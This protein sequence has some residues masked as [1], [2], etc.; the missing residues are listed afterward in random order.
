MASGRRAF[1]PG[2][3]KCFVKVNSPR[4]EG[5]NRK[6]ALF[7]L[8]CGADAQLAQVPQQVAFIRFEPA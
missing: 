1:A 2:G 6:A 5:R 8:R 4:S 3:A 7:Q